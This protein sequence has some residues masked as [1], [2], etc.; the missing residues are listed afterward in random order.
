MRPMSVQG[1][2]TPPDSGTCSTRRSRRIVFGAAGAL[3]IAVVLAVAVVTIPLGARWLAARQLDRGALSTAQHWLGWSAWLAPHDGETD[4]MRAACFRR[5]GQM[6]RWEAALE[7]ARKKR[8]NPL[9]L[10]QER[11]L[12][13][14]RQGAHEVSADDC[15]NLIAAGV[16]PYDAFEACLRGQLARNAPGRAR[17][18][19]APLET[20]LLHEAQV[21]YLQGV[22]WF[23]LGD[24][25]QAL[26]EFE[27]A[28]ARQAGHE[29]AHIAVGRLLEKQDRLAE[30]LTAYVR[31]AAA[32]PHSHT[33]VVGLA[34]VLRK[35]TRLEEAR[36]VVESTGSSAEPALEFWGELGAIELELGNYQE[37]LRWFARGLPARGPQEQE[38]RG[39]AALA[40]ALQEQT[41]AA[42]RLLDQVD[43]EV[44]TASRVSELLTRLAVAP[45]RRDAAD[46]LKRLSD[47]AAVAVTPREGERLSAA[48]DEHADLTPAGLYA[49][50]CSACHGDR[51]GGD[52]RAARHQFPRPRDLR[53]EGFRLVSTQ[54]G[55]PTVE[56]VARVVQRGMAGTSMRAFERMSAN[57]LQGLAREV[58]RLRREGLRDAYVAQLQAEGEEIDEQ[59]VV[60]VVDIR[61]RPGDRVPLPAI[62]PANPSAMARGREVYVQCGCRSCHG[63]DGTG[64]ADLALFDERQLPTPVRDLVHDSFKGG[65][66]PESIGL[67]VLAGMPGSPHPA[68]RLMTG[69][70]CEDL[71]H[72]CGELA[73]QPQR[74][75]TNHQRFL[76]ATRRPLP[77][78]FRSPTTDANPPAGP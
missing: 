53:R 14:I 71:V 29:L 61:T 74:R 7:S 31:F 38:P 67:R 46:E 9:R 64:A 65:H 19:L 57:Q 39:S 47:A 18:L 45:D 58:L 42:Q 55:N 76:E 21:A 23:N 15:R 30:A 1:S 56:D 17:Q 63:D 43:A 8:A 32:C 26:A 52:G 6:S 24:E 3:L 34:R 40:F 54:N 78:V 10:Q 48:G 72:Y 5:L 36:G 44:A 33:A 70:Q 20:A 66:E 69:Q 27:T 41:A 73:R 37:S 51:G 59:D 4:L 77:G 75:L 12:G 25:S 13:L 11:V 68:T 35:Q 49:W 62:G 28:V 50:H 60:E 16:P 2:S 22:Y